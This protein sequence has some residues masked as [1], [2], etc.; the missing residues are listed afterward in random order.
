MHFRNAF[1]YP[2]VANGVYFWTGSK[3]SGREVYKHRTNADVHMFHLGGYWYL[4]NETYTCSY[5]YDNCYFRVYD[6]AQYAERITNIWYEYSDHDDFHSN[7]DIA[8]ACYG[9]FAEISYTI[10]YISLILQMHMAFCQT[11]I[12]YFPK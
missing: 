9:K 4:A 10:I 1:Y 3:C 12:L 8:F 7:D 5:A 11:K 6:S 2:E